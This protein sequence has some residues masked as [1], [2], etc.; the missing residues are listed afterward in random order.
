ME[1]NVTLFVLANESRIML[2][3]CHPKS[4]PVEALLKQICQVLII[5]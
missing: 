1:K 4:A 3:S 5:Y 2:F